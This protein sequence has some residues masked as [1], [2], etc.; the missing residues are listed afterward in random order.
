RPPLRP[1]RCRN[2]LPLPLGGRFPEDRLDRLLRRHRLHRHP[3]PWHPLRL[4]QTRAG[5]ALMPTRWWTGPELG[6]AAERLVPGSVAKVSPVAAYLHPERLRET[7]EA[8]RTDAQT[9][10]IH[11]TNLCGVDFWDH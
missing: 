11:L 5:L 2:R 10:F 1:L 9:D 4:A 7:M 8:L 6:E 3:R